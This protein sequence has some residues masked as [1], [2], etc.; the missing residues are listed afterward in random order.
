ML[1]LSSPHGKT[2]QLHNFP[3]VL[4]YETADLIAKTDKFQVSGLE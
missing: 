3:I 4:L 2:F 1:Q